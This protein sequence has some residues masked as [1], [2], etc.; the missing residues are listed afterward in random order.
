[1]K[2]ISKFSDFYDF[3]T[4]MYDT[5]NTL[6]Y[7]RDPKYLNLCPD[8]VV[9]NL[10]EEIF[11]PENNFSKRTKN[12]LT[13]YAKWSLTYNKVMTKS[14]TRYINF[15][16]H[17]IGIYPYIYLVPVIL[18]YKL[19]NIIGKNMYYEVIDRVTDPR[20][21][22][23]TDALRELGKRYDV[24]FRQYKGKGKNKIPMARV[25]LR[26]FTDIESSY[27]YLEDYIS[28]DDI[29]IDS[30]EGLKSSEQRDV[31][32][33]LG[34]PC[35]YMSKYTTIKHEPEKEP[36]NPN[37]WTM[38]L[39]PDFSELQDISLK[40]FSED[41]TIYQRIEE[42]LIEQKKPREPEPI[43]D[44]VKIENHGFDKKTSFRKDKQQ[45]KKKNKK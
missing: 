29:I 31:F 14:D 1:M 19:K 26:K 2:I 18:V 38:V 8:V 17:V 6:E 22:F 12:I 16:Y 4:S 34:V 20:V 35:F 5:D 28:T 42:F 33:E 45:P 30:F 3:S 41:L 24:E 36:Y 44:V 10:S 15:E 23:D 37:G 27:F 25:M 43:P 32:L 39:N 21:C 9:D 11:T 40:Q 7:R 13:R